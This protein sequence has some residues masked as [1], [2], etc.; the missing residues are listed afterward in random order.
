[1]AGGVQLVL[2]LPVAMKMT[3]MVV[4]G[5]TIKTA[6]GTCLCKFLIRFSCHS[7]R[8]K[9]EIETGYS[10]VMIAFFAK[11][12]AITIAFVLQTQ[13]QCIAGGVGLNYCSVF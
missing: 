9:T 11:A 10:Q 13:W 7:S 8:L 2:M 1:M 3:V 4:I 5:G 6:F 12:V